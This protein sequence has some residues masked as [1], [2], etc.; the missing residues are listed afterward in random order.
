MRLRSSRADDFLDP[1]PS[2]DQCVRDQRAMAA[3]RQRLGT[4]HRDTLPLRS[5]GE[6]L[7][8]CGERGRLH[9]VRVTPER[10]VPPAG[11]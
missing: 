1:D 5:F 8:G 7:D 9:V 11:I 3:P 6:P 2:G 4:H 10:S